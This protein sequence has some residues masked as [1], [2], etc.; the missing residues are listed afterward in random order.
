[1]MERLPLETQTLYAE[2]LDQ[3]VA[4]HA[5]RTIGLAPGCFTTKTVK[6]ETY[7]YFQ[8]SDPGGVSRQAYVGKQSAAL[9]KVVT[10]YERGR[11][12]QTADLERLHRLCA[13]L[14]A[15]GALVTDPASSRV[16]KALAESGVF[17]LGGVLVGTHAFTVYGN[18]LGVRW[19]SAFVKTQDIDIAGQ[20][21]LDI[22]V[23]DLHVNVPAVLENLQMG[24]LPV[25]S[26]NRKE[27]STSFKIRGQSV[28]VDFLTPTR[29]PRQEGTVFISRL[30]VAAQA[31][32]FLDYLLEA[33]IPAGVIDGGGVLV[34]VPDPARYAFHKL[35]V[36]RSRDL[37]SQMKAEKDLNQAVQLIDV[38]VEDRPGDLALAWDGLR[39]RGR[40]WKKPVCAALA[41]QR[42]RHPGLIDR[43]VATIP[44]LKKDVSAFLA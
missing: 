20:A 29:R 37:G 26:F 42:K 25:P 40:E 9:A 17:H 19:D 22:A 2:F 3:L 23:P 14:R 11:S 6:G 10:S 32:K 28:R 36:S 39:R 12:I 21:S 27:P 41:A 8:Y 7:C 1:M 43:L 31:L 24:F 15:G 33:H 13:Q 30:G 16:L 44:L 5:R 34:N 18:L 4:M 35:L 38:L